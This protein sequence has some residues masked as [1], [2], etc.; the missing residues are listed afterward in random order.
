MSPFGSVSVSNNYIKPSLNEPRNSLHPGNDSYQILK[1]K[2]DYELQ[3]S[4]NNRFEHRSS[5]IK[6]TFKRII[7][8]L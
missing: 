2:L 8:V 6:E 7:L 4:S 3:D 1:Q 5:S